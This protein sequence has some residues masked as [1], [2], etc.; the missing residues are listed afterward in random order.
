M[1]TSRLSTIVARLRQAV[2]GVV[3]LFVVAHCAH[4]L[5]TALPVPLLPYVRD[6]FSLDYT[7]AA[8]VVSAFS[9]PYGIAQLPSGW[10]AD[11]F[12]ARRMVCVGISGVA[13]AGLMVGLSTNYVLLL[14]AS[15]LM[16]ALGGGYHPS[17]PILISAAIDP[18]RRGRALG[19]HMVGGSVAYFIAPL[20]AAGMAVAL[21]WRAGPL[22][23]AALNP[24]HLF[25]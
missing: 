17:A 12:G 10:L 20:I 5:V 18:A 4:H 3:I 11:R 1:K 23:E 21:G 15:A 6:E 22:A 19:L 16:G 13:F 2:P 14:V 7:R 8:L 25:L 9:V 24:V